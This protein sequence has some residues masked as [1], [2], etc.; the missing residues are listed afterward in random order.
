MSYDRPYAGIRV[1]DLS[2]G[3]AG[4]YCAMLLAQHGADVVKVEPLDGDWSRI[5]GTR[6]GG[7]T[8]YSI[9]GNLGKRA[10]ALDLKSEEGK[11]AVRRLLVGADVFLEG[12]RPGVIER[13]GFGREDVARIN[14]GLIYVSI[15]GFGRTG[16]L[17]AKPAMDPVLQ[18]FTGFMSENRGYDGIP[19]RAMPIVVDMSTA[20]YTH[21]AVAAALY[22]RR[23]DARGRYIDASL[24]QGAANLQVVRMMATWLEGKDVRPGAAPAGVFPTADGWMQLVVLRDH[25]FAKLADLLDRPAWK[26]DP[27]FADG[28]GRLA[29]GD[30]LNGRVAEVLKARPTAEWRDLFTAA[31]LQNEAVQDYFEFLDHPQV[32][33]TGVVSWL[34]QPDLDR[35]VPLPNPPGTP[36]LGSDPALARAPLLGEHTRA[37]LA[38]IGYGAAEIAAMVEKGVAKG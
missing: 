5:L 31:G 27:R 21:Q 22:A 4:P 32:A 18:A 10:L 34:A 37:V 19:H 35:E 36:P 14:P 30:E 33:A 9:A 23:D 7:H 15:S 26:S 25:D 8:A 13:L 28:A 16:P 3:I 6:W 1:V 2:Q 24:M 12:F 38:E 11:E 20:L 29:H 17:A